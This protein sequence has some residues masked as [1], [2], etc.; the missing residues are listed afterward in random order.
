[1]IAGYL[2][3]NGPGQIVSIGKILKY[4]RDT[5]YGDAQYRVTVLGGVSP[6]KWK[7]LEG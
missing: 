3:K 6:T 1:V 2:S 4:R 5:R 7:V